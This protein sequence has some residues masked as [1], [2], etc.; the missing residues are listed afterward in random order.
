MSLTLPT[1][2]DVRVIMTTTLTDT[3]IDSVILEAEAFAAACPAIE[4][5]SAII[6]ASILKWITA[7]MISVI[8][9]A[10][11]VVTAEALGDA[12][13][14]YAAPM[15]T[16]GNGLNATRFGQMALMLETTGCLARLG[17]PGVKFEVL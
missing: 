1:A 2:D 17:Q 14:S 13:K 4:S 9:G 10:G 6:Q 5:A 12:S 8:T 3:Q 11:G 15:Q 7:H 16:R